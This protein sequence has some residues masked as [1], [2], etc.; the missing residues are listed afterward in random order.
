M[1]FA[2]DDGLFAE[3][4]AHIAAM[5]ADWKKNGTIKDF[6]PSFTRDIAPILT[7]IAR[8]Q[9]VHEYVV[10]DDPQ[11]PQAG[12]HVARYHGTLNLLNFP[13]LGGEGSLQAS[14]RA[15]FDR[16]RDPNSLPP[17]KVE[18]AL[19]PSSL[20]DYYEDVNGRGG[21]TDPAY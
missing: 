16:M 10:G 17:R 14:R 21:E 4:L 9:R 15:L 2:A 18:P 8:I 5:R 20:G 6:K 3:P 12:G 11:N 1:D 7:S 13:N 19:M